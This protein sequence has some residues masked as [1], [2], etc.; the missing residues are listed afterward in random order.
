MLIYVVDARNDCAVFYIAKI[1]L[2]PQNFLTTTCFNKISCCRK[3]KLSVMLG[4]LKN[5]KCGHRVLIH[6]QKYY[7][8]RRR[9]L[10]YGI[11][12]S[13]SIEFIKQ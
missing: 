8:D 5:N 9:N 10:S 4:A 11:S 13:M 6:R 1:K 2:Y 12:Y 7:P 3:P